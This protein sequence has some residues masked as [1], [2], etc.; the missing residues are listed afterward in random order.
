MQ[1]RPCSAPLR[2]LCD[3]LCLDWMELTFES[4]A[5]GQTASSQSKQLL[6][7]ARIHFDN[8][9]RLGF[10]NL[11]QEGQHDY[12]KDQDSGSRKVADVCTL[13]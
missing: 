1:M 11:V 6:L 4:H 5:S 7:Q 9:T 8:I 12:I 2:Q 10:A 3:S 13:P